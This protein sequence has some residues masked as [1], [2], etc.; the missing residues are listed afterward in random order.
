MSTIELFDSAH[1]YFFLGR[2]IF[3]YNKVLPVRMIVS[4]Y[5]VA[6]ILGL[7]KI[8]NDSYLWM[9]NN[10]LNLNA[11]IA[12]NSEHGISSVNDPIIVLD[13]RMH[14]GVA[15]SSPCWCQQTGSALGVF[16]LVV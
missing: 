12:T 15:G 6:C 8:S 5:I 10:G 14:A 1:H 16:P 13:V 3:F 9:R 2:P 7:R 11:H 4:C